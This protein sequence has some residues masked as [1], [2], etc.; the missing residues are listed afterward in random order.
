[1]SFRRLLK[2]MQD[3]TILYVMPWLPSR[4]PWTWAYA[5][6][7]FC[8][9]FRFV[10]DEPAEAGGAV[11]P[12]YLP[13]GDVSALKRDVRTVWLLDAVDFHLSRRR[14][15]E[16]M[17]GHIEIDGQW[18]AGA[19]V[20]TGFHYGT[21][22]WV[23]RA[24][25]RS[26]RDSMLVSARLD[27]QE[28]RERP[29]LYRYVAARF[30][31]VA[32]IARLPVAF[33]PRIKER[34][35]EALARGASVVS[36]M[37]MPPRMAPRGQ[38]PVRWLDRDASLPDGSLALAREAGVPIVPWWV[39]IDLTSGRR[40]LVIG[41]ALAPEPVDEVLQKLAALLDHLIRK[42]PAAWLFWNE[43][44]IWQRDAAQFSSARVEGTLS[45]SATAQ[46]RTP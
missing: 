10:F 4:L 12:G 9:R 5:C 16:W 3:A 11:A 23:F 25:R 39:E 42:Q 37:D 28:Y 36:V 24:L 45:A 6:Y 17:P 19:F 21:G 38:R 44:I 41:E 31:E 26:G 18:P 27:P 13:I 40:K 29:V 7:R 32:R 34:L 46:E 14:P 2:A 35:L 20:A 33:R 8:A 15:I 22:L 1:M 43:W 30:D